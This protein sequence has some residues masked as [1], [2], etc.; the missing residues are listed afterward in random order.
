MSGSGK[1]NSAGS[2]SHL[3]AARFRKD[4]RRGGR[5]QNAVSVQFKPLV[6]LD[7]AKEVR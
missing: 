1:G 6:S 5:S 3:G 4:G 2:R 7:Q